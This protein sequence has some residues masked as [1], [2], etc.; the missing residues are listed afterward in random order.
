MG[1]RSY[2]LLILLWQQAGLEQ[3]RVV[4]T[5]AE[6]TATCALCVALSLRWR[7]AKEASCCRWLC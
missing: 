2:A 4:G 7:A 1:G 3:A 6:E 5:V